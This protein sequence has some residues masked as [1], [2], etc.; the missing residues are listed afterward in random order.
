MQ[1]IKQEVLNWVS[2]LNK[3]RLSYFLHEIPLFAGHDRLNLGLYPI[4]AMDDVTSV[5]WVG[6]YMHYLAE[7]DGLSTPLHSGLRFKPPSNAST[8][9]ECFRELICGDLRK[10]LIQLPNNRRTLVVNNQPTALS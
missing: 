6:Q 1:N 9:P 2:L 3:S 10:A 5:N 4:A 8:R 7:V